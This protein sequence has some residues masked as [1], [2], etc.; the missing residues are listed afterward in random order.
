MYSASLSEPPAYLM[1]SDVF[2]SEILAHSNSDYKPTKKINATVPVMELKDRIKEAMDGA[3]LKPLQLAKACKVTSGAV[4]QWTQGTTKSLK[5]DTA[6]KME[7]A[8]G[9]RADWI[10]YGTGEKKVGAALPPAPENLAFDEG[11]LLDMFRRV[12]KQGNTRSILLTQLLQKIADVLQETRQ[13][14]EPGQ[15]VNPKKQSAKSRT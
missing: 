10:L 1:A 4:T 6:S 12:P 7:K 14:P 2:M 9:Y 8:T 15:A 11:T 3:G 5:A 13:S